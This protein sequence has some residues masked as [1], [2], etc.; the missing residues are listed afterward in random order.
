MRRTLSLLL[1]AS[2][3][4]C[5]S[6]GALFKG[7]LSGYHFNDQDDARRRAAFDGYV[8]RWE[9]HDGAAAVAA[10]QAPPPAI[11]PAAPDR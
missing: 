5:A 7:L 8:D 3:C 10:R 9:A 2:L 1:V 4:G 6:D 11:L